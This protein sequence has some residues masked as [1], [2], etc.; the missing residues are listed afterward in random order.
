[1]ATT[2][3]WCEKPAIIASPWLHPAAFL[4][5]LQEPCLFH[6]FVIAIQSHKQCRLSDSQSF[7]SRLCYKHKR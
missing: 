5:F 4:T 1:M 3:R 6:V 2:Q 7:T